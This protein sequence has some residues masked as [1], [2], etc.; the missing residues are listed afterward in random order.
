MKARVAS[1]GSLGV[2]LVS[3]GVSAQ[4]PVNPA[5]AGTT[6]TTEVDATSKGLKAKN[7]EG[8]V[9]TE[10]EVNTEGARV[11]RQDGDS[12]TEAAASAEGA[13]V[14]HRDAKS[15]TRGELD[16][17]GVRATRE[18]DCAK[19]PKNEICHESTGASV[20]DSGVH[21]G[22]KKTTV[23]RVKKPGHSYSQ[24][25]LEAGG[26]YGDGSGFTMA[27]ASAGA[28]LQGALG[29]QLP[30]AKGGFFHGL[31]YR[32]LGHFSYVNIET[33]V[34][35]VDPVTLQTQENVSSSSSKSYDAAL[36]LGYQFLS[37]GKLNP[38]TLTQSGF[39]VFLGYQA[40]LFGAGDSDP[41]FSH[42]PNLVI[43]R[44]SYNA[45]TASTSSFFLSGFVLPLDNIFIAAVSLG[46]AGFGGGAVAKPKHENEACKEHAEC[47]ADLVCNVGVC[48]AP[49][50][51]SSGT[52]TASANPAP[53]PSNLPPNELP[54]LDF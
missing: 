24:L 9:T 31:G 7:T 11:K 36:A 14:E 41:Q 4:T 46:Y 17:K 8:D 16:E 37:Y 52:V 30:G 50:A 48:S 40:G 18:A 22:Y 12:T 53:P 25:M 21:F 42:G 32:A 38:K 6:S 13:S 3:L 51:P 28:G 39:G 44:P 45:G 10:A 15:V 20:D 26:I 49:A 1:S 23:Q 5:P 2:F 54:A 35:T 43:S 47:G 29:S 27:G 33:S 34:E 19:D